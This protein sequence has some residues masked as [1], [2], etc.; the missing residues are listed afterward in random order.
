[1]KKIPDLVEFSLFLKDYMEHLN[2]TKGKLIEDIEKQAELLHQMVD[3]HKT[4]MIEQLESAAQQECSGIQVRKEKAEE[5]TGLLK[6]NTEFVEHLLQFGKDDEVL[7][8]RNQV[9]DP[10]S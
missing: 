5:M 9:R 8:I 4:A 3:E 10:N 2:D 1:M 7:S 6:N